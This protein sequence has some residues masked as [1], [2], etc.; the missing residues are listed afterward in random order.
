MSCKEEKE[1]TGNVGFVVVLLLAAYVIN[2]LS[3]CSMTVST[4]WIREGGSTVV[5]SR[6]TK[7]DWSK[8]ADLPPQKKAG[9]LWS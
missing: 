6:N 9:W 7:E 3:G 1:M 5:E 2:A 8:Q 4:D